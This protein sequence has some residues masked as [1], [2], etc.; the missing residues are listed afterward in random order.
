MSHFDFRCCD[1]QLLLQTYVNEIIS[2]L[3]RQQKCAERIF[4]QKHASY[5]SH[6]Y[7]K[8][9]LLYLKTIECIVTYLFCIQ[10]AI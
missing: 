8:Q 5:L 6:F 9:S 2:M 1:E 4:P 10:N 7:T 3:T